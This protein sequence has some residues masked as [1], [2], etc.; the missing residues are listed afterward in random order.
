LSNLDNEQNPINWLVGQPVHATEKGG[1]QYI[2]EQTLSEMIDTMLASANKDVPEVRQVV[3]RTAMEVVERSLYKTIGV[4]DLENRVFTAKRELADFLNMAINGHQPV[5]AGGHTDL[6]PIGHPL[7]TNPAEVSL[8]TR[9]LSESEW[10]SAD[11]RISEEFRPLVASIYLTSPGSVEHN[12][13]VARLES[14]DIKD[15]PKDVVLAV[16]AA[17]SPFGG[18]NSF[19]D[20]SARAKLQRRDRLGRFAFMGGGARAF[21][22]LANGFI[23]SAVGRFVGVGT[24][25]DTFDVEFID[26]PVLGTGIY[27]MKTQNVA[28]VK[29]FIRNLRGMLKNVRPKSATYAREYAIPFNELQKLDAPNGWEVDATP[30]NPNDRHKR[31]FNAADGYALRQYDRVEDIPSFAENSKNGNVEVKGLGKKG[32]IDPNK[33]VYEL[34]TDPANSKDKDKFDSDEQ[35]LIGYFQSWGDI[36]SAAQRFDKKTYQAVDERKEREMWGDAPDGDFPKGIFE[37]VNPSDDKTPFSTYRSKN[38]VDGEGGYTVRRFQP[39]KHDSAKSDMDKNLDEGAE[40]RGFRSGSSEI[41]PDQPIFEVTRQPAPWEEGVEPD[42]IGYAQ[43]WEDV[44]SMAEA[45]EVAMPRGGSPR[46]KA[47]KKFKKDADLIDADEKDTVLPSDFKK[48]EDGKFYYTPE[49]ENAMRARITRDFRGGYVAE[50]Y[51]DANDQKNAKPSHSIT[52]TN[53]NDSLESAAKFI[54]EDNSTKSEPVKQEALPRKVANV[55]ATD[56]EQL[57]REGEIFPVPDVSNVIGADGKQIDPALLEWYADANGIRIPDANLKDSDKTPEN[58]RVRDLENNRVLDGNGREVDFDPKYSPDADPRPDIHPSHEDGFWDANEVTEE[59]VQKGITDPQLAYEALFDGGFVE[60]SEEV[61]LEAVVI[62][63]EDRKFIGP[64][65]NAIGPS[66]LARAASS[67][68]QGLPTAQANRLRRAI[69]PAALNEERATELMD[70]VSSKNGEPLTREEMDM[71]HRKYRNMGVDLTNM[72]MIGTSNYLNNNLGAERGKM[73]QLST[74]E[75]QED[76]E[77]A[78]SKLGIKFEPKVFT[79]DELTPVQ[80]EMDMGNVGLIMGSWLDPALRAKFKMDEQVLYVT[81]DGYVIDGHH[82]WAS[83]L[84][85]Q[86]KSGVPVE[87]KCVVVDLDHEDALRIC[88]EYNDHIGVTRQ[89]LGATSPDAKATPKRDVDGEVGRKAVRPSAPVEAPLQEPPEEIPDG[90]P[91]ARLPEGAPAPQSPS[92]LDLVDTELPATDATTRGRRGRIKSGRSVRD[93]LSRKGTNRDDYRTFGDGFVFT[94]DELGV[95][96]VPTPEKQKEFDDWLKTHEAADQEVRRRISARMAEKYGPRWAELF[97]EASAALNDKNVGIG[98]LKMWALDV[99]DAETDQWIVDLKNKVRQRVRRDAQAG[100]FVVEGKSPEARERYV[101]QVID[102]ELLETFKTEL[103]NIAKTVEKIE[104]HY[105]G[106]EIE[107]VLDRAMEAQKKSK[108]LKTRQDFMNRDLSIASREEYRKYLEEVGVE[109]YDGDGSE[110][111]EFSTDLTD[112]D[113][114]TGAKISSSQREDPEKRKQVEDA[115]REALRNKPKWMVDKLLAAVRNTSNGKIKVELDYSVEDEP[116]G[117]FNVIDGNLYIRVSPNNQPHG[118]LEYGQ[119]ASHEITHAFEAAIPELREYQW[120]FMSGRTRTYVEGAGPTTFLKPLPKAE[121]ISKFESVVANQPENPERGILDDFRHTYASRMYNPLNPLN[122]YELASMAQERMMGGGTFVINN[123]NVIESVRSG[124]RSAEDAIFDTDTTLVLGFMIDGQNS[125]LELADA[126]I[127][128]LAILRESGWAQ[129]SSANLVDVGF[130]DETQNLAS[131]AETQKSAKSLE[132]LSRI[133]DVG[134]K[135]VVVNEDYGNVKHTYQRGRYITPDGQELTMYFVEAQIPNGDGTY[136]VQGSVEITDGYDEIGSISFSEVGK[137]LGMYGEEIWDET[138]LPLWYSRDLYDVTKPFSTIAFVEVAPEQTRKGIAT[139]LL[140]FARRHSE[141]PIHHSHELLEDG[142]HFAKAVQ[143]NISLIEDLPVSEGDAPVSLSDLYGAQSEKAKQIESRI[144]PSGKEPVVERLNFASFINNEDHTMVE[145]TTDFVYT[146]ESGEKFIL[147]RKVEEVVNDSTGLVTQLRGTVFAFPEGQ[148]IPE[149]ID[150]GTDFAAEI[151][152][153]GGKRD[154][155]TVAEEYQ[156]TVDD[157]KPFATIY[158][159]GTKPENQRKGLATALLLVARKDSAMPVYHSSL[160]TMDGYRFSQAIQ[161]SNAVVDEDLPVEEENRFDRDDIGGKFSSDSFKAIEIRSRMT[162]DE[163]KTKV[164]EINRNYKESKSEGTYELYDGRKVKL[165]FTEDI[166]RLPFDNGILVEGKVEAVDEIGSEVGYMVYTTAERFVDGT[167]DL[168]EVANEL[169]PD[170]DNT[171]PF[172]VINIISVEDNYQKNGV[173]SAILEFARIHTVQPL[174]HSSSRSDDGRG[175]SRKIGSPSVV[176]EDLPV[177][178]V[179]KVQAEGVQKGEFSG[180]SEQAE[181]VISRLTIDKDKTK[182]IKFDDDDK[183]TELEIEG[184]YKLFD[185]R[186]VIIRGREIR[187]VTEDGDI[188]VEGILYPVD[189]NTGFDV[190]AFLYGTPKKREQ[191][192]WERQRVVK[193]Y[194]LSTVAEDLHPDVDQSV[195]FAIIDGIQV[196]DEWRKN[197][198]ASAL[199][200]MARLNAVQPIYHSALRSDDGIGFSRKIGAPPSVD[201]DL[202]E[203]PNYVDPKDLTDRDINHL[204]ETSP[205]T[206]DT[207]KFQSGNDKIGSLATRGYKESALAGYKPNFDADGDNVRKQI[208]D[209]AIDSGFSDKEADELATKQT[210]QVKDFIQRKN[211]KSRLA[212]Q[213]EK[214]ITPPEGASEKVVNERSRWA[215]TWDKNTTTVK[216]RISKA[217][218]VGRVVEPVDKDK[219]LKIAKG[220]DK[221]TGVG[222]IADELSSNVSL[223]DGESKSPKDINSVMRSILSVGNKKHDSKVKVVFKDSVRDNTKYT[224]GDPSNSGAIAQPLDSGDEDAMVM[225]GL[226]GNANGAFI[227][228]SGIG[229]PKDETAQVETRTT[230]ELGLADVDAVYVSGEDTVNEISDAL[231]KDFP[232]IDVVDVDSIEASVKDIGRKIESTPNELAEDLPKPDGATGRVISEKAKAVR[233]N[234]SIDEEPVV[235]FEEKNSFGGSKEFVNARGS[236]RTPNGELLDFFYQQE[237]HIDSKGVRWSDGADIT[238]FDDNYTL[239]GQLQIHIVDT[240]TD[241]DGNTIGYSL[242]EID[243]VSHPELDALPMSTIPIADISW[244]NVIEDYQ[245]QGIGTAMLEFARDIYPDPIYHSNNLS[246]AGRKYATAVANF[247][248]VDEEL[249]EPSDVKPLP[250]LVEDEPPKPEAT[251][252]AS[253]NA[254]IVRERALQVEPQITADVSSVAKSAGG[255]LKSLENRIKTTKSLA[256][257]IDKDAVEDFDGDRAEA[258]LKISDAVRYTMV[259]STG[260]YVGAIKQARAEFLE[261][262]YQVQNEKN[263]WKSDEYKGYTFKLVSPEGYPVEFQIHTDESY[264]I[265]DDLHTLY[266]ELRAIPAGTDIPRA[267]QLSVELKRLADLIPVPEDEELFEIGK[268]VQYTPDKELT[269]LGKEFED[270]LPI[271]KSQPIQSPTLTEE[272]LPTYKYEPK[273]SKSK[274][275][276]ERIVEDPSKT[277]IEPDVEKL[278]FDVDGAS[279]WL[280]LNMGHLMGFSSYSTYEES[281]FDRLDGYRINPPELEIT[282]SSR[283][284][285]ATYTPE[286]AGS[287][288]SYELKLEVKEV[289]DSKTGKVI[290]ISGTVAAAPSRDTSLAYEGGEFLFASPKIV[291]IDE[292]G[293]FLYD[294]RMVADEVEQNLTRDDLKKAFGFVTGV[295]VDEAVQREGVATAM[296]EFARQKA[297]VPIY[298]SSNRTDEGYYFSTAVQSPTVTEEELPTAQGSSGIEYDLWGDPIPSNVEGAYYDPTTGAYRYNPKGAKAK[299][300]AKRITPTNEGSYDD[301]YGNIYYYADYVSEDGVEYELVNKVNELPLDEE[302]DFDSERLAGQVVVYTKDGRVVGDIDYY[303]AYKVGESYDDSGLPHWYSQNDYDTSKPFAVINIA[304]V[305]SEHRRRGLATAM[306]EFARSNAGMPIHHSSNLSDDGRNFAQKTFSPPS[307]T[308]EEFDLPLKNVEEPKEDKINSIVDRITYGPKYENNDSSQQSGTYT[309]ED[310]T[311]FKL[312]YDTYAPLNIDTNVRSTSGQVQSMVGDSFAGHLT[313]ESADYYTEE[314]GEVVWQPVSE[315]SEVAEE[316]EGIDTSK[317]FSIIRGLAVYNNQRRKGLATAMLHFA[318]QASSEPIYHSQDRTDDGKAFSRAV[319]SPDVVDEEL[320]ETSAQSTSSST[321]TEK[322]KFGTDSLL[323]AIQKIEDEDLLKE[324]QVDAVIAALKSQGISERDIAESTYGKNGLL[325]YEGEKSVKDIEVLDTI[326]GQV[327]SLKKFLEYSSVASA[328]DPFES[329]YIYKG[330]VRW[331]LDTRDYKN[332]REYTFEDAKKVLKSTGGYDSNRTRHVLL[333]DT[334]VSVPLIA[335]KKVRTFIDQMGRE[336]RT[337]RVLEGREQKVLTPEQR[338]L[339]IDRAS[340]LERR[341][342]KDSKISNTKSGKVSTVQRTEE[343]LPPIADEQ[344]ANRQASSDKTKKVMERVSTNSPRTEVRKDKDGNPIYQ[345]KGTYETPS[346][347]VLDLVLE[348]TESIG[349]EDGIRYVNGSVEVF[350]SNSRSFGRLNFGIPYDYT[351]YPDELPY[352]VNAVDR[353]IHPEVDPDSPFA[354]IDSIRVFPTRQREGIA[355]AMLGFARENFNLPIYHSTDKTAR[356]IAFATSVQSPEASEED[357]PDSALASIVSDRDNNI[358]EAIDDNGILTLRA[359]RD[360]AREDFIGFN[361]IA[362]N[363]STIT[364][365]LGQSQDRSD[366]FMRRL[367]DLNSKY[368]DESLAVVEWKVFTQTKEKMLAMGLSDRAATRAAE[369]ASLAAVAYAKLKNHATAMK[370]IASVMADEFPEDKWFGGY[371]KRAMA[372]REEVKKVLKDAVPV[373]AADFDAALGIIGDKRFKTQWETKTSNGLYQPSTREKREYGLLAIDPKTP[374][375]KRPIYGFL[376]NKDSGMSPMTKPYNS[377]VFSANSR[378]ASQYGDVRFVL[379]PETRDRTTFT[380]LDSL[381]VRSLPQPLSDNPTDEQLDMAGFWQNVTDS[382]DGFI[383]ESYVEAQVLGGASMDDVQKI[384]VAVPDY[385]GVEA[386]E[387]KVN[388]L[389]AALDAGGYSSIEV[390]P[391]VETVSEDYDDSLNTSGIP[392]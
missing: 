42:V 202:P 242:A 159:I 194:P 339:A 134:D 109:M 288:D 257:K 44:Q 391:L 84:L 318:R 136:K 286:K 352:E 47:V 196:Y 320:P 338:R 9:S 93:F 188:A 283:K 207:L 277:E 107:K 390:V 263:F 323:E 14:A 46:R 273:S 233:K 150:E 227:S 256:R 310:G 214:A 12:F 304:R 20:R 98:Q 370:E 22:Q 287:N 80:A 217:L 138:K 90:E 183:Y 305:S 265:K 258:A 309:S 302:T 224:I 324:Q 133:A 83:A 301:S 362:P 250:P 387:D 89:T 292:Q 65:D 143:T 171:K 222:F 86:K 373:I 164:E 340:E 33:P 10:V 155:S 313:W 72:K 219:F 29:A 349:K 70:F 230:G 308:V 184:S 62:A 345:T 380:M 382:H 331:L 54:T 252:E 82:R 195:P 335:K 337:P 182:L 130:I 13:L 357:L 21:I 7:S 295:Y 53:L 139:A 168:D 187:R 346:G 186:E 66:R 330:K 216:E 255:F 361:H 25:S 254:R 102:Y 374:K 116:R 120:S 181:K 152:Y 379:K 300:V 16:T 384:V 328:Q 163:D 245:R 170:A 364:L 110:L 351:N 31:K 127:Q 366:E 377:D 213:V 317:S 52:S 200:E 326:N 111:F 267:R 101:Q 1:E 28:G 279:R 73:P 296:L 103:Y 235:T 212:Y 199:L 57:P 293:N 281:D 172:T 319:Q 154:V 360:S 238:V 298:H 261:L 325:P 336:R 144:V 176:E 114:Q 342:D 135:R 67:A 156:S 161:N 228:M 178:L 266:E 378:G 243:K 365:G 367:W 311:V 125:E 306:L 392:L 218:A 4:S 131:Q 376:A 58:R 388:A 272:E 312:E 95:G 77:A 165:L 117:W 126:Q 36:Q 322:A 69:N 333:G 260:D 389:R 355:T 124:Q 289:K 269:R 386:Y 76:F 290:R 74:P 276:A 39:G 278:V 160:R 383:R 285:V 247:E 220:E 372:T 3:K 189:K 87:L 190:G 78:L 332:Y 27:R 123:P 348:D 151:D 358:Q 26:D 334:E 88:N 118:L 34:Y 205:V 353:E 96:L 179:N 175:F 2:P 30:L 231:S 203:S 5:V 11:P 122:H 282:V 246:P 314:D 148:E 40:V 104:K 350:D 262:G 64:D 140:E 92:A 169:H 167:Y 249:P 316:T 108:E 85:A 15:V 307:L 41:E 35:T 201:E 121:P 6:L 204:L 112:I 344:S 192:D 371:Y 385:L 153:V 137:V 162:I 149:D 174:Y 275:V 359:V 197:G 206:K 55:P 158:G 284:H 145:T 248:N 32:A 119:T 347:E 381:D 132:V 327:I 253:D 274:S 48:G 79:P 239:V 229:A 251:A 369:G 223:P 368:L 141:N 51:E 259:T 303:G 100:K 23:Q 221:F 193:V 244:V 60:V 128:R 146:T 177:E 191:Y 166:E 198:V 63:M 59:E 113:M 68:L 294:S 129:S 363:I 209:R 343:D 280:N 264:E 236:Y 237:R 81:R 45:S 299:E 71:L 297:G 329:N 142:K 97:L 17:G 50:F 241:K 94:D 8:R 270:D 18:G 268:L 315:V 180:D 240:V 37:Q 354:I 173:A 105:K 356:G 38:N 24:D 226:M 210:A 375:G 321:I 19:L 75:D 106:S 271:S 225:A 215:K 43:D 211:D 56:T 208:Y 49:N 157:S 291:G 91:I 115:M 234:L 99:W 185:G 341:R 61:A 232:N 147:R